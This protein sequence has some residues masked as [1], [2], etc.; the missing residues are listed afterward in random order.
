MLLSYAK[1]RSAGKKW[2]LSDVLFNRVETIVRA[3][4][5]WYFH[6]YQNEKG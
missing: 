2:R 1:L 6:V 4:S 3:A 5:K